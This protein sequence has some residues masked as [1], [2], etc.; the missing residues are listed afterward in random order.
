MA[1]RPFFRVKIAKVCGDRH[2]WS[3]LASGHRVHKWIA[4]QTI[5]DESGSMLFQVIAGPVLVCL[6]GKAVCHD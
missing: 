5:E 4:V 3:D 6:A 1:W 2:W